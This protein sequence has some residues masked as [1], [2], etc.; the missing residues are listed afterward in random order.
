V[1]QRFYLAGEPA[2]SNEFR[3][4]LSQALRSLLLTIHSLYATVHLSPLSSI[5]LANFSPTTF[6]PYIR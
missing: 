3:P 2:R 4:I 1:M 5:P 6:L